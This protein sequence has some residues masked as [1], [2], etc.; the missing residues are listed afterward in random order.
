MIRSHANVIMSQVLLPWIATSNESGGVDLSSHTEQ[1][2]TL[3][4][5][6]YS[7]GVLLITLNI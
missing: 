7:V 5:S 6:R 4:N 3:L 2:G 1:T